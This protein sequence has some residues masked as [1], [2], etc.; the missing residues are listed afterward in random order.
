MDNRCTRIF[1]D[2]AVILSATHGFLTQIKKASA[3]G[4]DAWKEAGTK[5][6]I[7]VWRIVQFKVQSIGGRCCMCNLGQMLMGGGTSGHYKQVSMDV[8]GM[9]AVPIWLKNA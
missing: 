5:A 9:L 8:A 6:G 7:Q 4:E 1:W 3:E 2:A